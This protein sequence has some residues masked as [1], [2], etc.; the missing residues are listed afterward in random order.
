MQSASNVARYFIS[1]A[2]DE[3]S[4]DSISNLKLQKL[5]YYAQGVHLALHDEPLF[6]EPIKAW[7]HGPVVPEVYRDYARHGSSNIPNTR[8]DHSTFSEKERQTMDE[9]YQ[10]FGQ[11]SAWKL[12]NMTHDEPPWK[13]TRPN[14]TITH[15]KLKEYFKTQLVEDDAEDEGA[16]A[17]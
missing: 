17:E 12:R 15:E 3:D 11:F 4:G 16:E 9:V 5:L 1:I 13:D 6:R 2:N 10:V 7:E 8:I 14:G